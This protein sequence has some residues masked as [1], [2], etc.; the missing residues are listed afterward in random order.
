MSFSVDSYLWPAY[1]D[2]RPFAHQKITSLFLLKNERAFVLNEMGTGKTLSALWTCDMLLCAG[3]IRKVLIIGP[4]STMKSV[5]GKE[6]LMN[7]PHRKFSIAH[8]PRG[9]VERVRQMKMPVE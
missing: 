5:W 8:S 7:M 2:R 9:Q 1:G 6:I 3:K 4:L